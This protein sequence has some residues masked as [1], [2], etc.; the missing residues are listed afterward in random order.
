MTLIESEQT[1]DIHLTQVERGPF[2]FRF[3]SYRKVEDAKLNLRSEDYIVSELTPEK[4]IF[5]LC[6]GVGSSYYGNIGAQFLGETILD[7]LGKVPVPSKAVFTQH[8]NAN[9]WLEKLTNDIENE[10]NDKIT[11]ASNIIQKREKISPNEL[12]QLAEKTQR[13][14]FGTQSNFAGGIIWPKSLDFPNGLVLL[15]WLGNARIRI[16]N[17]DVEL[18]HLTNWGSN[19]EQLREV[20]SSKEGVVGHVYSYLTDFSKITTVMAYS[21]GMEGVE[22]QIKPNIQGVVLESIIRRAQSYKDDDVSY[23]EIFLA[24]G[25]VGEYSD[26]VVTK[27]R[28]QYNTV[29]NTVSN[30]IA[31]NTQNEF[32]ELKGNVIDLERQNKWL[33]LDLQRARKEN[34]YLIV[35]VILLILS[36]CIL[37]MMGGFIKGVKDPEVASTYTPF[38]TYTRFPTYTL[39]P[40]SITPSIEPTLMTPTTIP[41]LDNYTV[42]QP[43]NSESATPVTFPPPPPGYIP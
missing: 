38:P 1:K 2:V 7:W 14:D 34:K 20:W 4:A 23:L 28:G 32:K 17:G 27:I 31:L 11:V 15:F 39:I 37:L 9:S 8:N 21:D 42:I 36:N 6:D 33:S 41:A 18:T 5:G 3:A 16:F 29:G 40:P 22:E 10:L 19:P 25:N 30:S 24:Q 35:L 43:T 26:D 12:I 13:D